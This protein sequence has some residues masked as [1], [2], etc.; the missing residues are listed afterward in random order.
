M[1]RMG[2]GFG[3]RL[4]GHFLT[5]AAVISKEMKQPIKLVYSREDDMTQGTYRPSYHAYYKA[6]LDENKN[7]IA[8]QVRAGGIPESP[9][10][11]NR[12]PAGAV[13]NYVAE[14][15]SQVSNI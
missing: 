14:E 13:E 11:A 6:G 7:L 3:R 5:E 15:W 1:T 10:A 12:F 2:G 4:Y 9:L 8:F